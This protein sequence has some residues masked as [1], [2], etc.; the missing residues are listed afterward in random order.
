MNDIKEVKK[1]KKAIIDHYH[2]GHAK[3]DYTYYEGVLHDEC[4]R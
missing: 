1:I 2:E 4:A 3:H